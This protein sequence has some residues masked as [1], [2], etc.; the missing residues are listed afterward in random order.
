[1][2]MMTSYYEIGKRIVRVDGCY[3][4]GNGVTRTLQQLLERRD[5][6]DGMARQ[7]SLCQKN[8]LIPRVMFMVSTKLRP[9][10]DVLP[11]IRS[12]YQ[13]NLCQSDVG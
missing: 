7:A 11:L 13:A 10:V 2:L 8:L 12:L 1:M 3:Y 5:I 6:L 4:C 9:D